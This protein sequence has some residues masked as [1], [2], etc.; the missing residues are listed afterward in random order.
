M[1][2]TTLWRRTTP[3]G[4]ALQSAVPRNNTREQFLPASRHSD[5]DLNQ[6]YSVRNNPCTQFHLTRCFLNICILF[7]I[8]ICISVSYLC[9]ALWSLLLAVCLFCTLRATEKK[10]ECMCIHTWVIKLILILMLNHY[11]GHLIVS[12]RVWMEP[13]HQT[14]KPILN[15]S[16]KLCSVKMFIHVQHFLLYLCKAAAVS[17]RLGN[18]CDYGKTDF[19]AFT[20]GLQHTALQGTPL[21]GSSCIGNEC[22]GC[23]V[24]NCPK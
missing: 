23:D 17:L 10:T 1:S 19:L 6:S 13:D 22:W 18:S 21:I 11:N 7:F 4:E 8:Y 5:E 20:F 15:D 3:L 2:L 24:Q 12:C 14:R 9:S 16:T